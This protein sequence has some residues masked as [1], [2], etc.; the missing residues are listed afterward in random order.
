MFSVFYSEYI[1]NMF[2]IF[3]LIDNPV[4]ADSE[5]ELSFMVADKRFTFLRAFRKRFDFF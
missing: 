3:N 2:C 4:I 1:N 5:R